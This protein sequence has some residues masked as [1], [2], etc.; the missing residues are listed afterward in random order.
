MSVTTDIRK[1]FEEMLGQPASAPRPITPVTQWCMI[2]VRPGCEQEARDSLR[3]RG[4][5]AWWPNF[6][7]EVG[8]KDKETGK[9]YRR[10]VFVSVLPG[11]LISPARFSEGFW[12]AIDLAPG[13]INV[14]HGPQNRIVL[15]DD[16]DIATIHTIERGLHE[17]PLAKIGHSYSPGDTVRLLADEFKRL[18]P[19]KVLD[20]QQSGHL[21]VEVNLFGGLT[22]MQVLPTQVELVE[23]GKGNRVKRKTTD[24]RDRP[25]KSPRRH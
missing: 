6:Q 5:G 15:L 16:V 22:R 14:L 4:I 18:P 25:A 11:V 9:R 10:L 20:C 23:I 19:V 3:R 1:H 7:K 12:H 21:A 2:L 8:A 17:A 13:V 24:A